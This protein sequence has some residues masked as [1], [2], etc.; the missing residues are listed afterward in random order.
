MSLF[1]GCKTVCLSLASGAVVWV[2]ATEV[3]V[4]PTY[5]DGLEEVRRE[6]QRRGGLAGMERP[7]GWAWVPVRMALRS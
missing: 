2:V 3:P 7:T 6:A 1:Q 5:E 4:D